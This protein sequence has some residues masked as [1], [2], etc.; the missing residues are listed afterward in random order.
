MVGNES[1]FNGHLLAARLLVQLDDIVPWLVDR[2]GVSNAQRILRGFKK[3]QPHFL[4]FTRNKLEANVDHI[5]SVLG[6]S[7]VKVWEMLAK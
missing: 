3:G 7:E 6:L 2:A 1:R 5:R 4:Y